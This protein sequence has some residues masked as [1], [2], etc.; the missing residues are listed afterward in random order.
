MVT[1]TCL[2]RHLVS[3]GPRLRRAES[4]R[5][6]GS[7]ALVAAGVWGAARL[8]YASSLHGSGVVVL[9]FPAGL[10]LGL[11]LLLE[12]RRWPFVVAG[13]ILGN[14]LADMPLA[15]SVGVLL[16][17]AAAN[18][19]EAL[20]AA[21]LLRRFVGRAVRL[22]TVGQV[23]GFVVGA[24]VVANGLTALVGAAV[25][26]FGWGMSFGSGWFVWWAG[27]GIGMLV[28][29]PVVLTWSSLPRPGP[30]VRWSR[31]AECCAL[32]GGL[33]VV[34]DLV[35]G[36]HAAPNPVV[37][38]SPY[39]AFP[40]LIWAS[41][42]FGPAGAATATLVL[43]GVTGWHLTNHPSLFAASGATRDEQILDAYVYIALASVSSLLPA[44]IVHE[45]EE[46][47]R[48][49]QESEARYRSLFESAALGV[50]RTTPAGHIDLANPAL[51][52]L[53]G[54]AS[55]AEAALV[56]LE[57]STRAAGYDRA[58]FREILERDG[59][60]AGAEG[61]WRRPDG[62]V[63][64]IRESARAVR[65]AA[66]RVVAYEGM[67]EDVTRSHELEAQLVQ[68]QKMEAVGRLAGGVAHDFN[69]I[70]TAI[71]GYGELLLARKPLDDP[72]RRHVEQMVRAAD[73]AA[74]LTRQLL[75]FSRKELRR[76]RV[77]DLNHVVLDVVPMLQRLIGEDVLLVA[78]LCNESARVLA[79]PGQMDQ[80]LMNLSVNARD[81]LPEG[82]RLEIVTSVETLPDGDPDDRVPPGRYVI[83][84]VADTGVGMGRETLSHVF[85][86]FF[87]T[88]GSG[89]GTGL[90]LATVFG[91]VQQSGGIIGVSSAEGAGTTFRV[92]L[93]L[94]VD[95]V[96]AAEAGPFEVDLSAPRGSETIL[97]AEDD[98]H[99]RGLAA[100]VLSGLGYRVIAVPSGPAALDAAQEAVKID[101]LVSDVV[102]P[103]MSGADLAGELR[104]R[105][106]CANALLMSGYTADA[107]ALRGIVAGE[108]AFLHKP[109]GPDA[110]AR[111]VRAALDEHEQ[112]ASTAAR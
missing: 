109:F 96:S 82:G 85:E 40:F 10:V 90:G 32:L 26:R 47:R 63:V 54:C 18:A 111:A 25:L 76:P 103:E 93:P 33:A 97:L 71:L 74:T 88:K 77:I 2:S 20:V 9:W 56:D 92:Y 80:V 107:V 70:L 21:S 99:V 100:D 72:E 106:I 24:V 52:R 98:E 112:P 104:R 27:D 67:V 91:I 95:D 42:R 105:E 5:A 30:K 79:D 84:G 73:R 102:M 14:A 6:A 64:H 7:V 78:N 65:D 44:A 3:L 89:K 34:A 15:P 49:A 17:G 48:S 45:R 39:M 1:C 16:A 35:L 37:E 8:G 11:L 83:L 4:A 101:L 58:R 57:A 75:A 53:L 59:E 41:L 55:V 68:A 38:L 23:L 61:T 69:N 43:A 28:I 62:V 50:Y 31:I 87:T 46:A 86:P 51:L 60:V 110:F 13:A 22:D 19:L 94:A 81:A 66:G 36:D 12:R 108:F 29:A